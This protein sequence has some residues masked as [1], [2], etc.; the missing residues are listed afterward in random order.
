MSRSWFGGLLLCLSA[1]L[2]LAWVSREREPLFDDDD[3]MDWS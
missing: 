3:W 1:A 2:W